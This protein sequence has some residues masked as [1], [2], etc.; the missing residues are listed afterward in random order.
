MEYDNY[1]ISGRLWAFASYFRFATPG[2]VRLEA[3][4][5]TPDEVFVSAYSNTNGTV[6]IPLVNAARFPYDLDFD[7]SGLVVSSVTRYL[8]DNSHNVTMMGQQAINGSLLAARIEPRAMKR[9][10]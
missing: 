10:Y 8:T 9:F 3:Q 4:S 6:A 1:Y 7:A 5:G 2:S